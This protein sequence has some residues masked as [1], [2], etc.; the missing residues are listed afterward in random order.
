MILLHHLKRA[1]FELSEKHKSTVIGYSELKLWP[2][3]VSII[4]ISNIHVSICRFGAV[5]LG[6]SPRAEVCVGMFW[7]VDDIN[8]RTAVTLGRAVLAKKC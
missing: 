8:V 5:V 4:N 2:F 3:K 7:H 6:I 1:H